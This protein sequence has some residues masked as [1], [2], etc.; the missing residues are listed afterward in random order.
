MIVYDDNLRI[1][2]KFIKENDI[3][4]E[5]QL[6]NLLKN[7]STGYEVT[8]DIKMTF[9]DFRKYIEKIPVDDDIFLK[10]HHT[11]DGIFATYKVIELLD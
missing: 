2:K 3:N 6:Q 1:M 4:F 9:D 8:D 11:Y 5:D 7:N 10:S